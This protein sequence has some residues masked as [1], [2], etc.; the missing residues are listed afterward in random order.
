MQGG[1]RNPVLAGTGHH[2]REAV[3]RP[4]PRLGLGRTGRP[5]S[6][7]AGRIDATFTAGIL[8]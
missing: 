6:T 4:M 8:R 1:P 3:A 5:A 2:E 7:S